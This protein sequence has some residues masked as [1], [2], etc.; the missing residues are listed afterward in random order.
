MIAMY[1]AA[2]P[3]NTHDG[4]TA[5]SSRPPMA[6]PITRDPFICAEFNEIAAGR[7]ARVTMLGSSALYAGA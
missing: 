2:L 7:L 4:P 1:V 6:G 3:A 5:C